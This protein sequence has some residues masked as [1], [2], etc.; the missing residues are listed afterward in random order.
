MHLAVIVTAWGP[1]EI[2]VNSIKSDGFK[3]SGA[4]AITAVS[5]NLRT[6][7]RRPR[8]SS[9]IARSTP[10]NDVGS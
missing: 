4:W 8:R 1:L 3:S 9:E 2:D 6:G 5:L 10:N 7:I